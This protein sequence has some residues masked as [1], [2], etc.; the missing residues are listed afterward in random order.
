MLERKDGMVAF[1]R[2]VIW[3]V[4]ITLCVAS[5]SLILQGT[6]LASHEQLVVA[7]H[8]QRL[9]DVICAHVS[10][11]AAYVGILEQ[12]LADEARSHPTDHDITSILVATRARA[13][14]AKALTS[15][16]RLTP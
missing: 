11:E 12:A 9:L 8:D 13:R 4:S 14:A 6:T 7:R 3:L 2:T 15:C 16:G 5:V 1:V 10:S